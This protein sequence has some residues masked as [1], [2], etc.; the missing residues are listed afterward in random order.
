MNKYLLPI[1]ALAA[2]LTVVMG[3]M[4]AHALKSILLPAQLDNYETAL[5]YQFF[6]LLAILL[7]ALLQFHFQS[8]SFRW[9]VRLFATGILL[10]CGSIYLIIVFQHNHLILPPKPV[11]AHTPRRILLNSR[12]AC[13]GTLAL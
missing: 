4:G 9:V 5:R 8:V 12:L 11:S 10:F 13:A 2:G 7:T 6:H 1:C 3:A